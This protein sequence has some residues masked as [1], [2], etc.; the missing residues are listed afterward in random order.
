MNFF[1][2]GKR[3]Y[4]TESDKNGF[5]FAPMDLA[6]SIKI[7]SYLIRKFFQGILIFILLF[8]LGV[9][10]GSY[11][12]TVDDMSLVMITFDYFVILWFAFILFLLIKISKFL[13]FSFKE[14]YVISVNVVG[15]FKMEYFR[16]NMEG[17]TPHTTYFHI[18]TCE[19]R[20]TGYRSDCI[21]S[22]KRYKKCEIGDSFDIVVCG[23]L[24]ETFFCKSFSVNMIDSNTEFMFY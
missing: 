16:D 1:G 6:K 8:V 22:E 9:V 15:D 20:K 5:N 2:R 4:F 24:K 18:V 17:T 23:T 11:L 13:K 7:H 12:K 3:P 21:V 10:A 19:D 14:K